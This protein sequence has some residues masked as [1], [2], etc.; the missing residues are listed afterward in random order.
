MAVQNYLTLSHLRKVVASITQKITNDLAG[1]TDTTISSPSD[2]QVLQYNS[3]TSK[4]ENGTIEIDS[5][6]IV[7]ITDNNSASLLVSDKSPDEIDGAIS[8]GKT[9][10][11][12]VRS[13]SLPSVDYQLSDFISSPIEFAVVFSNGFYEVKVTE[14][15]I[16]S[17]APSDV[18]DKYSC[19]STCIGVPNVLYSPQG[20][21]ILTYDDTNSVWVNSNLPT[22]PTASSTTPLSDGTGAVGVSTFYARA[23]HVHPKITQSLSISANIITLTGSDGTTSSV[24]L[25]VYN[26]GVSS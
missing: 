2:G 18:A 14:T 24:T 10:I 4:W 25:P 9:V 16:S 8:D 23:D 21:Q 11:A 15:Q 20:G 12:S 26:G 3:T 6:F 19:S 22:I 1:L 5:A 17:A 7:N 13:T